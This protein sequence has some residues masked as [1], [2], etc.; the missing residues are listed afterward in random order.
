MVVVDR[1][2]VVVLVVPAKGGKAHAH[3]DPW[4]H[5]AR[6]VAADV[7][8]EGAGEDGEVEEV[9]G[10]GGVGVEWVAFHRGEATEKSEKK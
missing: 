4:Y 10:A 3:I 1:V 2:G 9:P 7:A 8:E 5:H 6:D